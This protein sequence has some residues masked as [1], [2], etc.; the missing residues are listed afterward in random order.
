MTR[1]EIIKILEEAECRDACEC[2]F[3]LFD[4]DEKYNSICKAT[5]PP[6]DPWY[7]E[8]GC[9]FC[10]QIA[11]LLKKQVKTKVVFK[12]YDGEIVTECGN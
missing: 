9:P 3:Y 5:D 7:Q 12:E 11:E 10:R 2:V 8:E 4:Y 1:E 6:C